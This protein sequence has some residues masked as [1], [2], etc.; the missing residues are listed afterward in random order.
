MRVLLIEDSVRLAKYVAAGLRREGYAV[1]VSADGEEGQYLAES[2]EY[3]VIVLDLMLP[4]R[5]GLSVLRELRAAGLKTHVL[6]MT[7]KDAVE[8]RVKGLREGA[9][10]YLI[11][12]FAFEELLAR[13]QALIRREYGVKKTIFRS[14]DVDIDMGSRAAFR[15][16]EVLRLKP[17][18]YALLEYL[19][20]RAGEVVTRAEIE[21]HIYDERVDPVSNVVDSA[22]C[23]L[24]RAIDPPGGP[25]MIQTRRGMGYVFGKASE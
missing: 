8:D 12:P 18:E 3:D 21:Q 10:D 14:G 16:G 1:D 5:D 4:K 15:C 20:L 2:G 13:L 7:A 23:T 6:I 22:I 17:R 19:A 24:R 11:K 9:D 25:S